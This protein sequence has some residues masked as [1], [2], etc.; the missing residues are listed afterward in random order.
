ML[1]LWHIVV[2]QSKLITKMRIMVVLERV[3]LVFQQQQ[4]NIL[5]ILE[6]LR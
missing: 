5:D 6:I 2:P 1:I 3:L 4:K